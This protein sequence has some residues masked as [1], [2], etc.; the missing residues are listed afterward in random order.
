MRC[1]W[2]GAVFATPE[3][4][5]ALCHS[6]S[7]WQW[8]AT[9]QRLKLCFHQFCG[10]FVIVQF[11]KIQK[12]KRSVFHPPFSPS[13][14]QRGDW[15]GQRSQ[16]SSGQSSTNLM[17]QRTVDIQ[18]N[19]DSHSPKFHSYIYM[20]VCFVTL[21]SKAYPPSRQ[22]VNNRSTSSRMPLQKQS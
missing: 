20:C 11:W 9:F 2:V 7:R 8:I 13:S 16:R 22:L 4:L 5:V 6:F 3:L 17:F 18:A 14:G 21:G 1:A 10:Q 19:K 12:H 15:L